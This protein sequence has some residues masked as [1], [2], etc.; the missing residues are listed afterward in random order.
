M[1]EIPITIRLLSKNAIKQFIL[2]IDLLKPSKEAVLAIINNISV[3]FDRHEKKQVTNYFIDF[4]KN[5]SR[6]IKNDLFNHVLISESNS[7]SLTFSEFENSIWIESNNYKENTIY[8][9]YLELIIRNFSEII[10][11]VFSKR[12]GMRFINEFNCSLPNNLSKIFNKQ[13]SQIIKSMS[14][15]PFISRAISVEEFNFTDF[16]AR[17]QYGVL[18]KFYPSIITTYD[19]ILDIDCFDDNQVK[20]AEWTDIVSKLNHKSY[21]LF[22]SKMNSNYL[23]KLK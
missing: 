4:T 1:S 5:D 3:H 12:I 8:K 9:K 13:T 14:E 20:V 18:N 23:K 21:D 10:P 19:S 16:K 22:I 2:K 6:Y 11:E 15:T 17:V 7:L